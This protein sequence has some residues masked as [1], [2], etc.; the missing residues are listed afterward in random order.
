VACH[1]QAVA[2]GIP[3]ATTLPAASAAVEAIQAMRGEP[4]AVRSLHEWHQNEQ[5]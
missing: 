1:N 2:Y 5:G 4:V 3:Y